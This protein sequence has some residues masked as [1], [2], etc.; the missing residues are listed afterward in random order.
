MNAIK[1][2]FAVLL[3][4]PII[5]GADDKA[6]AKIKSE[7]LYYG[8]HSAMGEEIVLPDSVIQ[9]DSINGKLLIVSARDEFEP[10]SFVVKPLKDIRN[11]LPVAADFKTAD[12]KLIPASALDIRI[13]KVL[14]QS[15]GGAKNRHIRVLKPAVLLHDD[16][17]VKVDFDKMENYIRLSFPKEEKYQWIS[18][19]DDSIYFERFISSVENPI[20]DAKTIQPLCLR[21][22]FNQQ[23]WLTIH[24]PADAAP[25]LYESEIKLTADSKIFA[26][27]PVKLRVL[28]FKLPDPKTNY[29]PEKEFFAGVYYRSGKLDENGP[30]SITSG[31]R[32]LQQFKAELKNLLEHGIRYPTVV[33]QFDGYKNW[34][35]NTWGKPADG[36]KVIE[37][38]PEQRA[39]TVRLIQILR[40]SGMSTRP[41]FAHT[42]GNF[43]FRSS[44]HRKEHKA[45]LEDMV[46]YAHELTRAAAG[47]DDVYFYGVDEAAGDALTGEFEI[48]EDMKAMNAKVFTTAH[49]VAAPLVA[50]RIGLMIASGVPDRQFSKDMHDKGGLIWNYANPQAGDKPNPFPYRVNFGFGVYSA[51]YDGIAT[52]A[53]N[54]SALN[55]WNDF[56]NKVEPDLAFVIGT[57]DGVVDTPSWEGYREGIDDVRYATKLR[58]E[59]IKTRNGGDKEKITIANEADAWLGQINVHKPG[60]DP[61]WTRLQVIEWILKLI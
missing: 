47:H 18:K 35:W 22:D 46:A 50:G 7:Y 17:L 28:P 20:F 56:D 13:V 8:V 21:K 30:G 16:A 37:P 36:G 59:I 33:M 51:N 61:G 49:R 2:F 25:G 55:P 42:G 24:V 43:G 38:T 4:V 15:G 6:N 1:V 23:F 11:F 31:G 34:R 26:S 39:Q 10:A 60:F 3:L 52:Y 44:Y 57:A 12:G 5:A 29:D 19:E 54:V 9:P 58:Q 27:I 41:L 14:V 32:N 45:I 53:Y 48:W 40:E